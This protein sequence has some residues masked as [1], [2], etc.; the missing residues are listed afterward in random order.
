MSAQENVELVK[1][2]YA[3]FGTGDIEALLSLFADD[4]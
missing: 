2:G 3:A 1:Q 4:I